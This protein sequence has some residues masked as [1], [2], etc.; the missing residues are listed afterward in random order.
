MTYLEMQLPY[1]EK[2]FSLAKPPLIQIICTCQFE[3]PNRIQGYSPLS[4]PTAIPVFLY[5]VYLKGK[6]MYPTCQQ[7]ANHLSL[8]IVRGDLPRVPR[9][10][11]LL[12]MII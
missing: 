7:L 4:S 9:G 8:I 5:W 1:L 3:S 6:Y 11:G 10:A 2:Q 12:L